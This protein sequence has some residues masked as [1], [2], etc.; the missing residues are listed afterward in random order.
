VNKL[1][2][3]E[4]AADLIE[5]MIPLFRSILIKHS[6]ACLEEMH[7]FINMKEIPYIEKAAEYVHHLY[8]CKAPGGEGNQDCDCGAVQFLEAII[9]KGHENDR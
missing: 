1:A 7:Q 8:G 5:P 4:M 3:R 6:A 9:G 2:Y